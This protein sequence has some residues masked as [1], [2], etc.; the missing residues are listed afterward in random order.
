MGSPRKIS[1]TKKNADR[2]ERRAEEEECERSALDGQV[3]ELRAALRRSRD[4]IEAIR[5][6]DVEAE[7]SASAAAL[8][9][10]AS[11]A[12]AA[13]AGRDLPAGTAQ[14]TPADSGDPNPHGR[15]PHGWSSTPGTGTGWA[16]ALPPQHYHASRGGDGGRWDGSCWRQAAGAAG[17][18]PLSFDGYEPTPVFF[19]R[20]GGGGGRG[21]SP[22]EVESS[23]FHGGQHFEGGEWITQAVSS[24]DD[25]AHRR[26]VRRRSRG[27]RRRGVRRSRGGQTVA[28]AECWSDGDIDVEYASGG[29]G[30]GGDGRRSRSERR[31]RGRNNKHGHGGGGSAAAAAE[32]LSVRS[33]PGRRGASVGDGRDPYNRRSGN[34]NWESEE[35]GPSTSSEEDSGGGGAGGGGRGRRRR[36]RNGGR[37]R[38]T[39]D[40]PDVLPAAVGAAAAASERI[41]AAELLLAEERERMARDLEAERARFRERDARRE[42]ERR[43][44]REVG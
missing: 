42:E 5:L 1:K 38:R 39:G 34:R 12:A 2:A 15:N 32:L 28:E 7:A 14:L 30:S 17:Q 31:P 8:A 40:R 27:G 13:V 36:S 16:A 23:E 21:W 24:G 26:L 29:D 10:A 18:T 20:R 4:A 44:E 33:T 37:W 19:R 41:E 6:C 3:E 35:H 25:D 11:T 9:A 22:G 43:R